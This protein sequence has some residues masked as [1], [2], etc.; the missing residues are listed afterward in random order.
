MKLL[1]TVV[2][3]ATAVSLNVMLKDCCDVT[4]MLRD[5]MLASACSLHADD[6]GA[7]AGGTLGLELE[8]VR[9]AC[10]RGRTAGGHA[11]AG[12][13][14]FPTPKQAPAPMFLLRSA[15]AQ[16]FAIERSPLSLGLS[17]FTAVT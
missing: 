1:I 4:Q 3:K 8:G 15:A 6:A 13:R 7:G 11:G 9:P 2:G 12:S 14:R 5:V 10:W 17:T 16:V